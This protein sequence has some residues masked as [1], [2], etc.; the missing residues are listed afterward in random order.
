MS[1]SIEHLDTVLTSTSDWLGWESISMSLGRGWG[2][3]VAWESDSPLGRA[4]GMIPICAS[5]R[6]ITY[7]KLMG[8][9]TYTNLLS[10]GGLANSKNPKCCA[11]RKV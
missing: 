10:V 2:R 11:D 1:C 6:L 3:S 9:K 7:S 8:Y 4:D 5:E